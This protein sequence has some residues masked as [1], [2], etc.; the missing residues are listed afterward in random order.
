MG[1]PETNDVDKS[2]FD[3]P[4]SGLVETLGLLVKTASQLGKTKTGGK[5]A[6]YINTM[7]PPT[8][9]M[10]DRLV[11]L[12][13]EKAK[14]VNDYFKK[15]RALTESYLR[16][17]N[18]RVIAP[19]LN[20]KKTDLESFELLS[21]LANEASNYK[22]DPFSP[23]SKYANQTFEY[24]DEDGRNVSENGGILWDRLDTKRKALSTRNTEAVG[25]LKNLFG[26]YQFF[27]NTFLEKLIEQVKIRA[28]EANVPD[29]QTSAETFEAISAI[30]T[31]FGEADA[32]AYFYERAIM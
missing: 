10:V 30:R 6:K 1:C 12:G 20:L 25:Y 4:K 22:I 32:D 21:E 28:G 14:N 31:A 29:N 18:D 3:R 16:R 17:A 15:S 7:F 26:E 11:E 9:R 5:V 2:I 8:Q 13:Y 23:R 24:K 27:R 19:L